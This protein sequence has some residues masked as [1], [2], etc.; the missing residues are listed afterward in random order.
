MSNKD[1]SAVNDFLDDVKHVLAQRGKEYGPP[2]A[3][4]E[5]I[6]KAWTLTLG[7]EITPVTACMLM[8]DLKIARL[9]N[10]PAN[11]DSMIDI[12]GYVCCLNELQWKDK[13][14]GVIIA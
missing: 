6:A 7:R 4:F 9:R 3:S 2:L 12:V 5:R 14:K 8:L 13:N 11:I 1:M 10:N